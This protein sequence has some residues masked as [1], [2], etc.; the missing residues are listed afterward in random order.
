MD[1]GDALMLD[2]ISFTHV[3]TLYSLVLAMFWE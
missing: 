3:F 1:W 2:L